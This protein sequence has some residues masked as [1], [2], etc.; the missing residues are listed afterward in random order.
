MSCDDDCSTGSQVGMWFSGFAN[1]MSGILGLSSLW[2]PVND[3]EYITQMNNLKSTQIAW[4]DKI[5]DDKA[6]LTESLQEFANLNN[7]LM[8]V[9][10]TLHEEV[11]SQSISKNSLMIAILF[12]VVFIILGYLLLT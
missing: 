9:T 8:Q 6:E 12:I 7:D 4:N 10:N 5:N 3:T 11:L 2:D 1:S